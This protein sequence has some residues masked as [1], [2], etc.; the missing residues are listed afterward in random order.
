VVGVNPSKIAKKFPKLSEFQV[1]KPAGLCG[2]ED[3]S[4][5]R[6]SSLYLAEGLSG[7]GGFRHAGAAASVAFMDLKRW[8]R[9]EKSDTGAIS[10]SSSA[11]A[12]G[13]WVITDCPFWALLEIHRASNLC[14]LISCESVFGADQSRCFVRRQLSSPGSGNRVRD[15]RDAAFG[16]QLYK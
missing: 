6:K 7:S 3:Q 9:E 16:T 14:S 11:S 15:V 4:R 12:N 13:A 10:P 5:F 2:M 8:I 1:G